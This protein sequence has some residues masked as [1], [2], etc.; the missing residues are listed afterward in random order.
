MLP[1]EKV[2]LLLNALDVGV[3]CNTAKNFDRYCFPQK[4]REVM[5]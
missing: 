1:F 2:P 5:A 3:I 4:A